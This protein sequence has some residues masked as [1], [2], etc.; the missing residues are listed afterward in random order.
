[1][2]IEYR[3]AAM[4]IAA[5]VSAAPTAV[6]TNVNVSLVLLLL[7]LLLPLDMFL[8]VFVLGA[9]MMID[10]MP[11]SV[12]HVCVPV[13]VHTTHTHDGVLDFE[14]DERTPHVVRHPQAEK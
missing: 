14:V 13:P 9:G 7:L 4:A 3:M 12:D 5:P 8:L 1:M 6:T 11:R 2:R 10:D